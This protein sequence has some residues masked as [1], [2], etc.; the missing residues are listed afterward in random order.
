MIIKFSHAY[1]KMPPDYRVSRLLNIEAINLEDCDPEFLKKDT[2][3]QG[4]GH[5]PLP[6]KGKYMILRL[7]SSI[8]NIRWQTIR[9][10]T[11]GKEKYYRKYVGKFVDCEITKKEGI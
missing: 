7:E 5:Y 3:I 10:W 1:E 2:A 4:G 9:R 11:P 6:K 8:M